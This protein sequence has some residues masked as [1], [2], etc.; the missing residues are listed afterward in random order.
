[1]AQPHDSSLDRSAAQLLTPVLRSQVQDLRRWEDQVREQ[2]PEAVHQFRVTARRLRSGLA[3]FEPLLDGKASRNL[4]KGLRRAAGA[5]GGGRDVQAVRARLDE[6]FS[7]DADAASRG[8]YVRLT[9]GLDELGV[10]SWQDS[11]DHLNGSEYDDFTRRLEHFA[12]M[13]PW[14][15]TAGLPA[16]EALHPILSSEWARFRKTARGALDLST[17]PDDERLHETRKASKRA[18]YVAESLVV[19]FGRKA[20]RMGQ[21]AQ[22]V[23]VTLGKHQD[24]RLVRD[25]LIDARDRLALTD[26]EA[27]SLARIQERVAAQVSALGSDIEESLEAVERTSLRSWMG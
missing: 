24:S 10:E 12:D 3:G 8:L 1:M 26:D 20:K 9:Q 5:V 14:L 23:Q 13:P 25:F 21:A 7:E 16:K 19:V 17:S 11:Q 6:L 27:R 22:R 18:R 4:V 2:R 15:S